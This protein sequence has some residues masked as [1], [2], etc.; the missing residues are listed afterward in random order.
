MSI[1]LVSHCMTPND[2]RECLLKDY[3]IPDECTKIYPGNAVTEN[4]HITSTKRKVS[5]I[6]SGKNNRV[7]VIPSSR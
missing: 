4:V 6:L 3:C 7:S 2:C 1:N 5:E